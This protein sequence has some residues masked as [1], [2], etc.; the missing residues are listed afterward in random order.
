MQKKIDEM[1]LNENHDA[2]LIA[3][4]M[5]KRD[6]LSAEKEQRSEENRNLKQ[7]VGELKRVA[8]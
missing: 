3:K 6:R 7:Q 1:T 4:V 8:Q 5:K 2:Q